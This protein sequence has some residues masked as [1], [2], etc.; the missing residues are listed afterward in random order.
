[1]LLSKFQSPFET[2]DEGWQD[3]WPTERNSLWWFVGWLPLDD[4]KGSP[5][6][7]LVEV[8]GTANDVTAYV[9]AGRFLYQEE[10]IIGKWK[11]VELKIPVLKAPNV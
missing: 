4:T 1:M 5:R 6:L 9:G 10:R 2:S 3:S 11:K 8:W 7:I